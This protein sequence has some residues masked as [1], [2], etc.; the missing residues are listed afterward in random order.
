MSSAD[1]NTKTWFVTSS[2]AIRGVEVE[3]APGDGASAAGRGGTGVPTAFAGQS[4]W[5]RAATVW[6]R[7]CESLNVRQGHPP[8]FGGGR[9]RQGDVQLADDA[10]DRGHVRRE[11]RDDER[12]QGGHLLDAPHVVLG[13]EALERRADLPEL[14]HVPQADRRGDEPTSLS[15]QRI[16]VLVRD[17]DDVG[18]R[19]Q[20]DL[21]LQHPHVHRPVHAARGRAV[22]H[23]EDLLVREERAHGVEEL[24]RARPED[25]AG[26]EDLPWPSPPCP[27]R[28]T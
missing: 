2:Y 24:L 14:G 11:V 7:A 18:L 3:G 21:A 19:L 16:H 12:P 15:E 5:S 27:G 8:D 9:R 22:G 28:S 20:D 4:C 23:E 17:L 25:R 26:V 10:V 6:A 13:H 1:A